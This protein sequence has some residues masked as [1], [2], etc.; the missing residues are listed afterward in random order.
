[1][2]LIKTS[3]KKRE[4][5][6]QTKSPLEEEQHVP[7]AGE[8]AASL[9]VPVQKNDSKRSWGSPGW[10]TAQGRE[11]PRNHFQQERGWGGGNSPAGWRCV[12]RACRNETLCPPGA[13]PLSCPHPKGL[14][15]YF[16]QT[17]TIFHS[18]P[19]KH[20]CCPAHFN[21]HG[22]SFSSRCSYLELNNCLQLYEHHI[23]N[24][25][26]GNKNTNLCSIMLWLTGA[27]NLN[28]PWDQHTQ[29]LQAQFPWIL[30]F[31]V[32]HKTLDSTDF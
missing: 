4:N 20:C 19:P 31:Y 25:N 27:K 24:T 5:L 1:M 23:K 21:V 28:M 8:A 3:Q 2:R 13:A 10:A 11:K 9:C 18:V 32:I 12:S 30:S 6:K 15:V 17:C 14:R 7:D 22:K 16:S 29:H 26:K